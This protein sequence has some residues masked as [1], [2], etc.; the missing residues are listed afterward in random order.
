MV[1]DLGSSENEHG[2]T[3]T[4]FSLAE[5]FGGFCLFNGITRNMILNSL[6]MHT[7]MEPIVI[8][9]ILLT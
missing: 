4:D 1:A 5:I 8:F 9:K 3:Y 2:L 6:F 7:K